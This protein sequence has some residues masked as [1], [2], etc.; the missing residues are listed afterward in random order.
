MACGILGPRAGIEPLYPA[1]EVWSLNNWTAREIPHCLIFINVT[2]KDNTVY[3]FYFNS[4]KRTDVKK[5][6]RQIRKWKKNRN[7][8]LSP[9]VS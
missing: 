8:F 6:K 7:K 1:W 4:E 9:T 3:Q 2:L 5:I